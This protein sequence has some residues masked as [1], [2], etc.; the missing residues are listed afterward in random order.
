MVNSFQAHLNH[1]WRI[2]QS[3]FANSFL[4]TCSQDTTV[5][6]WNPLSS[7]SNWTLLQTYTGHTSVVYALEFTN[8]DTMASG[9]NEIY[10]KIWSITTGQ[11]LM[12]INVG[13]GVVSLKLLTNGIHLA[14]GLYTGQIN[15]Y[16]VTTGMLNATLSGHSSWVNDL[17]LMGSNSDL[18]ASSSQDN[19]I[20]IWNLTNNLQQFILRG[21]QSYVRGL[22]RISMDTLSSCSDDSAI[23]VW[24]ITNGTLIR[25][26]T[27]HTG[28]IFNS[29]DLIGG[30]VGGVLG[31]GLI[32]GIVFLVLWIQKKNRIAKESG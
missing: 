6:I 26:L 28:Q 25:T 30:V 24:N 5:K 13:T 2:R 4:A 1:I 12:S 16:D 15:V 29:L 14:S 17:V 20:I 18:L 8:L 10:I 22:K 7:F 19:L 21:H 11:T 9:G 3:Q 23:K 27:G 31:L 32:I